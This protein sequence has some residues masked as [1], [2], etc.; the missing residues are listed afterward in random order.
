M[1]AKLAK[2]EKEIR[3]I[4]RQEKKYFNLGSGTNK[5]I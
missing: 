2:T 3:N 1:N 4:K 5:H